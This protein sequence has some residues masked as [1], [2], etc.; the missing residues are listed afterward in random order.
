MGGHH[1][2]LVCALLQEGLGVLHYA[3]ELVVVV[4][5]DLGGPAQQLD[6]ACHHVRLRALRMA[7]AGILFQQQD[8]A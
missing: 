6:E 3:P 2:S 1:G 8:T 4:P 7:A 5:A